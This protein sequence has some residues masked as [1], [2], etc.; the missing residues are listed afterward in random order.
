M[1]LQVSL[2]DRFISKYQC[3]DTGRYCSGGG[4]AKE[5]DG[6]KVTRDCF[7]YS[8]T[9]RCNYPSRNDCAKHSHCYSLG[10]RD[11]LLRDNYGACVNFKKEF[12]CKRWVP[13]Y[14]ESETVRYGTKDKEGAEGF[15]CKGVPCIDGNCIDKSY[16]MDGDMVSSISQLGAL[17][18]GKNSGNGFKIFEGA[19]RHCSKK[20]ADYSNCCRIENP[21][22]GWGKNLGHKCTT[23]EN[24]LMEQRSKNLCVYVGK[25]S[26]KN[27]G[28]TTLIKHHFCCFSNL[29]EKTVQ[30]Q[31]R[32]QLGMSFGSG[33]NA[34][35]RGLTLE[36]LKR[37][38]FSKMDFSEVARDMQKKIV[39][40]DSK[41]VEKRIKGSFEQN[42]NKFDEKR[43]SDLNNKAAG[44]NSK[45]MEN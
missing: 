25:A 30:V 10:T 43:P 1:T 11:C 37:V 23:D 16:E 14:T 3:T 27:L 6:F 42:M 33:G 32:R 29:L 19:P 45:I 34:D 4:G 20:P 38:D 36:E 5:V 12:S 15:V 31:G 13:T 26:S 17:S 35:C 21:N 28:V 39:M 7:E 2:A 44:T 9:K 24:F 8:Y 40:P 41:D 18:Q 22:S